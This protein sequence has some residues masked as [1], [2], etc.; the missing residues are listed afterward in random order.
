MIRRR[1][2][3]TGLVGIDMGACGVKLLQLR[4]QG[5]RLSVIG[6]ARIDLSPEHSGESRQMHSFA[7]QLHT[8][9]TSGMFLGRK[10]VVT[11][12]RDDVR[13]QAVRL[14]SMCEDELAQATA[15]EAAQRFGIER[16]KLSC[17]YVRTGMLGSNQEGREEVLLVGAQTELIKE[18]LEPILQAGFRPVAVDTGFAALTRGF[19]RRNRRENDRDSVRAILDVGYSGSVITI[20]RG[21]QVAFSKSIDICGAMFNQ[22]IAEHL[23]IETQAA[24][25]LRAARIADA[26]NRL[27][28]Q[29]SDG[30]RTLDPATDRA[31]YEAIRPLI[32]K[33]VKEVVLCLRYYGVT[34]RGRP[35]ETIILTGGD[36]LEPHLA[37]L[38]EHSCK[39]QTAFDDSFGTM[40]ALHSQIELKLH[41]DPGPAGCWALAAG[42]SMRNLCVAS[43]SA[44][45]VEHS[46]E[47]AA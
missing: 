39:S 11:L 15:W 45:P 27:E 41:R 19:S 21:D 23:Q 40:A 35:P 5:K 25:E 38:V 32:G 34:F 10:C 31:I 33:L 2:S 4:E 26:S 47:Q 36:A 3:T 44:H 17:D 13:V 14:P 43:Q 8:V 1:S 9:M 46:E 22:V 28:A 29:E 18:R 6:A 30:N 24:A 37:E 42:L 16:D 7:D 12:P 20:I